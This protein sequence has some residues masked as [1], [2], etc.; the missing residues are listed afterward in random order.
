MS[1]DGKPMECWL[2]MEFVRAGLHLVVDKLA[3]KARKETTQHVTRCRRSV[4]QRFRKLEK[5]IQND[6]NTQ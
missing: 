1:S 5:D 3:E 2:A 6:Q 4:G